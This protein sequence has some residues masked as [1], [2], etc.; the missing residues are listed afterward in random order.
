MVLLVQLVRADVALLDPEELSRA[1]A[2]CYWDGGSVSV[3][4][5]NKEGGSCQIVF[6]TTEHPYQSK[7]GLLTVKLLISDEAVTLKRGSEEE[8]ELPE[9]RRE[10]CVKLMAYGIL[11]F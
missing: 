3:D 11:P 10:V 8:Q 6:S 4:L 1:D 9:L 7:A 5:N 2:E